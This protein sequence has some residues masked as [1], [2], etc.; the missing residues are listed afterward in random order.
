M[1]RPNDGNSRTAILLFAHGSRVEEANERVRA[2]AREVSEAGGF[3]Y[4]RAAFLE[5]GKPD[6]ETA[7]AH[8]VTEGLERI[9]VLP[10]FLT[11]G[12]HLRRDLPELLERE[13]RLHPGVEFLVSES[14]ESHPTMP[15]LL[16]GRI[17]AVTGDSPR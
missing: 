3:A 14:L 10:Y 11:S 4:V 6:L 17:R 16:V 9:V 2:L 8:A 5:L 13:R 12:I 15:S 7:I 1:N